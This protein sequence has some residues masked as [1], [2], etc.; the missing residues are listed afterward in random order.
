VATQKPEDLKE[1]RWGHAQDS[2]ICMDKLTSHVRV[3]WVLKK[4]DFFCWEHFITLAQ[5]RTESMEFEVS[6]DP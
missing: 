5:A 2:G 3:S 1:A 4:S 6:I